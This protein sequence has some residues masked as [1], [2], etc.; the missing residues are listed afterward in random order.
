MNRPERLKRIDELAGENS[1][2]DSFTAE[3]MEFSELMFTEL[4]EVLNEVHNMDASL[5]FWKLAAEDHLLAEV[6]R[7]DNL[8]EKQWAGAPDWYAVVNYS[9]FPTIHERIRNAGGHFTRFLKTNRVKRKIDQQLRSCDEIYVGFKRLPVTEADKNN[10][11]I[12]DRYYP[13]I[14]GLGNKKKR[15]KL[16]SIA[17]Q[18]D[19]LFLR[20]IIRRIP[21]V[22]VEN[23]DKLYNGVELYSPEKKTFHV[24]LTDSLFET[25]MIAKYSEQGSKL[26][27][28]QHGCYYGEVV[29]KYRGY[30]EHT[31][32]D[33]F[34]TWG[35]R[36]HEIDEPWSAYRL[37]A[38]KRKFKMSQNEAEQKYDLMICYSAMGAR[39]ERLGVRETTEYLL[40][41]VDSEKYPRILARPR[42]ENSRSK[43]SKQLDYITDNRVT[44]AP[45]G[46][47]IA[48][49]VAE[50]RLVFQ[51]RIPSTNFME[52]VYCDHPVT[53]LLD[54]D[55][56]TEIVA[57]YYKF[58]LDE[59]V[60][61]RD[62]RS[63]VQFLN[64]VDLENWWPRIT[65]SPEYQSYK[66]KFANSDIF[67]KAIVG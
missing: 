22:Y 26:I 25:M 47:S 36:N 55:Q 12:V 51:M 61:H 11:A 21:K 23:F 44:V 63:A 46:S 41:R 43:A 39:G 17:N 28:Y 9:N 67:R 57:P 7:K 59:G 14:F 5:S 65:G 35:Y 29:H 50:S 18:Y 19:S 4:S 40:S 6:L 8:R 27:W 60:L 37:E 54:N 48:K 62:I 58:F 24:H 13:F 56:P 30:F 38:F 49:Q 20:N 2:L 52:C 10:A 15:D 66:R 3:R 53:G 32:G 1:N 34:R 64:D 45:D 16:N 31:T 42:P 33:L